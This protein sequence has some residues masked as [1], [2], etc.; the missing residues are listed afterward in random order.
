MKYECD[1]LPRFGCSKCDYRGYQKVHVNRHLF[2]R[3][4][5]IQKNDIEKNI[6]Y[7]NYLK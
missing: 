6:L 2:R 5:I 1:K 7:F 4:K 3:H